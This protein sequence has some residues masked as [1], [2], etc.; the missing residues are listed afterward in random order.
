MP[1]TDDEHHV[2]LDVIVD[3]R[4]VSGSISADGGDPQPFHGRLGLIT[5]IDYALDHLGPGPPAVAPID[6]TTH[7]H[8]TSDP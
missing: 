1:S 4:T 8:P 6:D 2:H 3:G 7:E 5:A